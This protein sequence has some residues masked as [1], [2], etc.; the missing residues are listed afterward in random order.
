[1]NTLDQVA[2][3]A[4]VAGRRTFMTARQQRRMKARLD[5]IAEQSRRFCSAC[6][7]C[8]DCKH[9]V[10][11]PTN[12][13]LLNQARFFGLIE[14]AKRRYSRLKGRKEGDQSAEACRRCG[15]CEPKCPIKVPIIRRLQEVAATL[16]AP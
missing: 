1:M 13:R 16:G 5:G 2:A 11:I 15:A 9:G 7:Y 12:F 14:S 10:D 8:M 6:G 4:G 3:N